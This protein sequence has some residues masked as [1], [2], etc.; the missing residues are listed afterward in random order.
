MQQLEDIAL[1]DLVIQKNEAALGEL[2]DRY[3]RLVY[4]IAINVVGRPEDAEEIT[5][6]V[7]TRIWEKADTYQSEKAKVTTWLTRMARNRAID[8]LRRESVR[9][10]KHSVSWAQVSPLPAAD[11]NRPEPAAHLTMQKERV[12]EAIASLPDSQ[13][14]VLA[15]AYFK[16]Y[17]HSEIARELDIPLG[18]AKGRIRL[19]MQKLR[20]LLQDE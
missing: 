19:G 2:Y 13:Q 3:H 11:H 18:T 20:D 10:M 1:I 8:V 5:L 12:R 15:L 9:P 16:G 17:S 7:F 4:S 6:D 14:E